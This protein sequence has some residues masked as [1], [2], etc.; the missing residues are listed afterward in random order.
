MRGTLR[1]SAVALLAVLAAC[2]RDKRPDAAAMARD[3]VPVLVGAGDIADCRN[4]ASSATAAILDTVRGT[5]FVAGDA[6]Y[7]TRRNPDPLR[8]CYAPTWGRHLARTRPT[9]G[10]HE[11]EE[12]RA[13]RYFS[14]FGAQAGAAPGGYYSYD[15]GEWH[16]LALNTNIPSDSASPQG[17]WL[18]ADLDANAGKCTVAYMHHP[19]F[20]SGPHDG[21]RDVAPLWNA[22]A[23]RGVSVVIAGHD[24]IYERFAPLDTAGRVDTE[25]GMRQ[26]VVGTG[27]AEAYDIE[28]VLEGSE[29]Q[30]GRAF[31]VLKLTLYPDRYRWEFIPVEAEGFRDSGESA[32]H[33]THGAQ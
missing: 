14:Y 33:A 10:N 7:A 32:C 5:I 6:G 16:V 22:L 2:G 21:R 18:R 8:T 20:S 1:R 31:G 4:G 25:L 13:D 3:T 29:V 28:K 12:G 11:Y 27:G 15:L 26:F 17:Q 23:E 9:P 19:R 30:S 24:H